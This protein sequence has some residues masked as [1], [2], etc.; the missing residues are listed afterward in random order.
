[1]VNSTR[2][3]RISLT[4]LSSSIT[5]SSMGFMRWR[6]LVQ[7][8]PCIPNHTQYNVTC[9]LD[10]SQTFLLPLH[11]LRYPHMGTS[12]VLRFTH[13]ATCRV[14][15]LAYIMRT[16]RIWGTLERNLRS[17]RLRT[18]QAPLTI[19]RLL[20]L[21]SV[22]D[23]TKQSKLLCKVSHLLLEEDLPPPV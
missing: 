5:G 9:L 2:L 22:R 14:R 7:P 19:L 13:S 15:S 10:L 6:V 23:L 17:P 18:F 16:L 3:T 1:M 8:L 21:F 20:L 4:P 12:K 11:R